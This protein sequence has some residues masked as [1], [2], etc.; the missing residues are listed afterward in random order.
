[1]VSPFISHSSGA[2]RVG[3]GLPV[4][5]PDVCTFIGD[6]CMMS[7]TG[8]LIRPNG[9]FSSWSF[10]MSLGI[11]GGKL[12]DVVDALD[13]ARLEAD[14]APA[15]V[16]ELVLPAGLHQIQKLLVLERRISS[17]DQRQRVRSNTSGTG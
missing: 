11:E 3:R 16:V 7:C 15:A 10:L 14:L 13:V 2:Y 1:M 8:P 9:G 6:A 12:R 17:A 5:P 4:V